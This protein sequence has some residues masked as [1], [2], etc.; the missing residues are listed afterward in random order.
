[1]RPHNVMGPGGIGKLFWGTGLGSIL[2]M[3]LLSHGVRADL[4]FRFGQVRVRGLAGEE[5]TEG[6]CRLE[7]SKY[8]ALNHQSKRNGSNSTAQAMCHCKAVVCSLLD[9]P[10][11][12]SACVRA[13]A[14]LVVTC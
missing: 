11:R 1:M 4:A 6:G 2:Q 9:K 10:D 14:P 8:V 12:A 3:R 7:P 5:H 13:G